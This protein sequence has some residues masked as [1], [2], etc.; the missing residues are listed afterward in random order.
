[1]WFILRQVIFFVVIDGGFVLGCCFKVWLVHTPTSIMEAE[2]GRM[3]VL[4]FSEDEV[5]SEREA[6]P[7]GKTSAA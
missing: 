2:R 6:W 1:M 5:Y 3:P 7:C 4:G